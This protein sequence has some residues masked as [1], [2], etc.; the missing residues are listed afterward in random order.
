MARLSAVDERA[1][2]IERVYHGADRRYTRAIAALLRDS[3]VAHDI[4]QDA[5]AR[6]LVDRR[7]YR[8]GSLP[9]W[10]W[11]IAVRRALD[12]GRARRLAPLE[13]A[14]DP[15]VRRVGRDPA[16]AD[17]V[18]SLPPRRRLMVL[19]RYF[20]DLSYAEIAAVCGVARDGGGDDWRT[21]TPNCERSSTSKE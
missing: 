21:H 12:E 6:A 8:G 16:V 17:A 14:L 3:E 20:A 4:V 5:F 18:R 9:A 7:R 15:G 2:A 13:D 19:L 10:I 11:A 1:A